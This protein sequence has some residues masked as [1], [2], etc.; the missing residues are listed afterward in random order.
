MKLAFLITLAAGLPLFG[1]AAD[2]ALTTESPDAASSTNVNA[3]YIIESVNILGSQTKALSRSLR[4]ELRRVVGDNLD[5]I[6]LQ[7][8]ASRIKDELRVAKVKI[9]VTRGTVPNHVLVNFEVAKKPVDLKVAKFLYDSKQG[10][11]GEASA[12]TYAAGN[13]FTLGLASDDDAMVERYTGIRAKFERDNLGTDRLG[14]RFEFDDFHEMWNQATVSQD[15]SAIYRSRQTFMPEAKVVLIEPLEVDFGVRFA[16]FR[17]STPGATTESSNAVVS[18]LRYHQRWGSGEDLQ[19]Q[20]L[21]GS[22]SMDATMHL[23]HT[24]ANYVR[25]TA[26]ARYKFRRDRSSVEVS[27]M[28]GL[29]GGETPLFDRF[30]LGNASMLR[31]WSKFDLDPV[32]GSHVVYGSVDYTYRYYQVFYDTG[33]VWDRP[34]DRDQKQSVGAG[35]KKEGFQ[36]AVAFPVGAPRPIPV[37][38][39]GMNF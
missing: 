32:G 25:Q 18:T 28:A 17:L 19:E 16:R 26:Q 31:G 27:F 9:H 35:F 36:L 34:Q 2:A 7:K 12:T 6:R 4:D 23:L 22:Y 5:S 10:W 38:Y 39:A 13:A 14:M 29:T 1:G 20:D 15:P 37:F 11:S 8:L 24:D 30:V 21:E 3:R 33:A